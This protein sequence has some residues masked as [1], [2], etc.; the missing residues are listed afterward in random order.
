MVAMLRGCWK[1]N[2]WVILP[3]VVLSCANTWLASGV[4]RAR[5]WLPLLGLRIATIASWAAVE[6]RGQLSAATPA[7]TTC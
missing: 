1:R 2:A 5:L 4:R 7:I 3:V 6:T